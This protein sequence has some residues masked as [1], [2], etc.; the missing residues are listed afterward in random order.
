MNVSYILKVKSENDYK[1]WSVWGDYFADLEDNICVQNSLN[2]TQSC[3]ITVWYSDYVPHQCFKGV[4]HRSI[5]ALFCCVLP[6]FS[7]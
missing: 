5:Q 3:C 2:R 1:S 6:D 7:S 4:I